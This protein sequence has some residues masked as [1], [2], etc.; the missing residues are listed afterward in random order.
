[1]EIWSRDAGSAWPAQPV[2]APGINVFTVAGDVLPVYSEVGIYRSRTAQTQV[3]YNA[4]LW[5][6]PTRVEAEQFFN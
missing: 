1:M 4:G 6:R 5:A 2:E 3:L